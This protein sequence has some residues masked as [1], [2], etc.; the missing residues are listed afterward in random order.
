[1]SCRVLQRGMEFAMLDVLVSKAK[2]QNLK[3]IIGYYSRTDKNKMVEKFYNNL[4][5]TLLEESENTSKWS[6]KVET[7][8]PLKYSIRLV[9]KK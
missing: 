2:K 1:M 9:N 5:F 6:L 3:T 8:S 7:Y 4:G